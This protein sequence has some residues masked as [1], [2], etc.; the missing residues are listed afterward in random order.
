MKK[1]DIATNPRV[2][3]WFPH[4]K[5]TVAQMAFKTVFSRIHRK[6]TQPPKFYAKI[7]QSQTNTKECWRIIATC[8]QSCQ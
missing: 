5:L 2:K 7:K 8:V 6:F 4:G 1:V 3:K